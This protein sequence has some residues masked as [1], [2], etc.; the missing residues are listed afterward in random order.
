MLGCRYWPRG[1]K[2]DDHKDRVKDE[3][4][5]FYTSKKGRWKDQSLW[6]HILHDENYDSMFMSNFGANKRTGN[7][8][9]RCGGTEHFQYPEV[10]AE[11]Y[12]CRPAVDHNNQARMSK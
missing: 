6:V 2:C 7:V 9:H 10:E 3:R 5:G 12:D 8:Q 11:Y 1:C 4:V